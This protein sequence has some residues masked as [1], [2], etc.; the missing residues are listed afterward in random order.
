MTARSETDLRSEQQGN[1]ESPRFIKVL[2]LEDVPT[3]AELIERSLKSAG[4]A[5]M[6]K[7]VDT[8]DA[9]V[10]ALDQFKP[11]IV[12]ADFKLP[13]YDGLSAVKFVHS[14]YPDMP[15]IVVTGVLGDETAV[16]LIKAGASDYVLKDRMAR[17]PAAVQKAVLEAKRAAQLRKKE[18]AVRAAEKNLYAIATYS[19]DAI[20]M[21]NEMMVITF[22]NKSAEACFGY[23]A[24]ETVGRDIYSFLADEDEAK[25]VRRE[26][27][28]LMKAGHEHLAGLSRKLRIKK[29]DGTV[30]PLDLS[31]SFIWLEGRWNVIGVIRPQ[32]M[33]F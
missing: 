12:L 27:E 15:V 26:V 5:F 30:S 11:D 22:W 29:R 24:D 21:M 23:S 7:R 16:E 31:I 13:R 28:S 32:S 4:M 20:M 14:N 2:L 1:R 8:E 25:A 3:D 9:F 6:A 10:A 19:Q 17:L 18:E 33:Q